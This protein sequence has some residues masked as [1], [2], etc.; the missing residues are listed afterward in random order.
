MSS[1][2]EFPE[3]LWIPHGIYG[4]ILPWFP[5]SVN[6]A[7]GL[8]AVAVSESTMQHS[9]ERIIFSPSDL[10]VFLETEF[11]SWMDRW[12]LE[13]RNGTEGIANDHGLPHGVILNGA[14]CAPD[15]IDEEMQLIAGKG[16][17]H[18]SA[19][20][21]QL[22]EAGHEVVEIDRNIPF[23]RQAEQTVESMRSGAA[24]VFQARL[25]HGEFAGFADFLARQPGGSQ[26]GDHHYEVWDT[27]LARTVKP[28][29]LE[30][31]DHP[32]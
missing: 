10:T 28:S 21:G 6:P 31:A 32:C 1:A 13:L 16:I 26:F 24:Y 2:P 3:K 7:F 5:R 27:K 15:E 12:H 18:E 9:P 25:E 20:L 11:G 30:A 23:E 17:E 19:F 22:R 8:S 29:Y 4:R 14:T